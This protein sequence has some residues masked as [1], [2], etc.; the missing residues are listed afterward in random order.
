MIQN[1]ITLPIGVG[2][3]VDDAGWLE[4]KDERALNRT[5]RSQ[6]SRRHVP[7]DIRVLHEIGKGLGV[8]VLCNVV[9]GDWDIKNRLRGVPH[10][11]WDEKGWDAA[12]II[13]KNRAY[14]DECFSILEGS[15]HLEY[16]LHGLQ[17]AY[18][19]NGVF[20]DTKYLYPFKGVNERGI[21]IRLPLPA[22]E[23]DLLL[24]LFF[25]IYNDW[26]FKK[27]IHVFEAGSGCFGTPDDEYNRTFARLLREHGIG[28]WEWGGWPRDTLAK[29]GTIYINSV[30]DDPFVVWNAVGVDPAILHDCFVQDGI[31]HVRPNICG[32]VANFVQTQP[33]KNFDYV[34]AWIDYFRRVTSPFGAMLA[35]D[36]EAAASQAVYSSYAALDRID[37]G[38]RID[39]APVDAVRTPIVED[40]FFV[41][42]RERRIPRA[43]TGATV[44][45]HDA[46]PDHVIYKLARKPGAD[47][48][49]ILL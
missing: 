33:E 49:E 15:Q 36:N 25:E 44:T 39:L 47:A 27:D 2:I 38:Y 40:E 16:G 20:K 22:E 23:F 48:V 32:H 43:V 35:R 45:L 9:L 17:H 28:I 6:L 37:G 12:S 11:T 8:K 31:F 19:E 1:D 4:G 21:P 7:D 13:E 30:G 46:R 18:F 29:D 34:P 10:L 41:S 26:G 3:R 42:L 5:C 24:D 14:F